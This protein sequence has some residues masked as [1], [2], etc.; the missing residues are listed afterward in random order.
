VVCP[1]SAGQAG[2]ADAGTRAAFGNTHDRYRRTINDDYAF[3]RARGHSIHAIIH[4]T[5]GGFGPGAVE[6]LYELS[7]KHGSR[8]G[9]DEAA[10]PWCARS[11]RSLHALKISVAIHTAA[12]SEILETVQADVA[13]AE[14]AACSES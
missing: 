8:L 4:E 3:A 7:R 2:T 1:V 10:A 5:F 11:F 9:A 14:G 12:A 13:A 6:L